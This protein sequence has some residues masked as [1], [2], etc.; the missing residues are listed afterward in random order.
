MKHLTAVA[1]LVGSVLVAGCSVSSEGVSLSEN[2]W[3]DNNCTGNGYVT[4]PAWCAGDLKAS[5][6]P[7]AN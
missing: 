4:N 6:G 1:L 5:A 2:K 7:Y 3:V